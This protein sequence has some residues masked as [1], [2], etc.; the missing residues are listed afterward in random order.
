MEENSI[1]N[2]ETKVDQIQNQTGQQNCL[3]YPK[4]NQMIGCLFE[5][6]ILGIVLYLF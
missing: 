5:Q 1:Q 3:F 4:L 2:R 6:S